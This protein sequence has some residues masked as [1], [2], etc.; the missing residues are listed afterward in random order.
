MDNLGSQRARDNIKKSTKFL[1]LKDMPGIG[2]AGLAALKSNGINNYWH[3]FAQFV[4]K[5][6]T[7]FRSWLD[8]ILPHSTTH[9]N[10]DDLS[11]FLKIKKAEYENV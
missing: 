11:L 4:L 3:L 8:S 9:A 1:I 10:K 6:D 7:A 2:E 5:G